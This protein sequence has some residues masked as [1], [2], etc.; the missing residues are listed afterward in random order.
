MHRGVTDKGAPQ[1]VP[2]PG[3]AGPNGQSGGQPYRTPLPILQG[4]PQ[5]RRA[6]SRSESACDPH[7]QH[8]AVQNALPQRLS[9]VFER[10]GASELEGLVRADQLQ[11]LVATPAK[12]RDMT[13]NRAA[14]PSLGFGRYDEN[15][16]RG[17]AM[18]PVRT[19]LGTR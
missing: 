7:A 18:A 11:E 10:C 15:P 5:D 12:L 1:L 9:R 2:Y 17:E 14:L 8:L 3:S 6:E 19:G 4:H 16:V 13:E